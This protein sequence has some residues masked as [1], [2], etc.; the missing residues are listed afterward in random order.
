MGL[1]NSMSEF[2]EIKLEK[3]K[4]EEGISKLYPSLYF[5][6]DEVPEMEKLKF[7]KEYEITL[8]VKPRSISK[9]E[10]KEKKSGSID[11][12][13]IAYKMDDIDK[14]EAEENS[15]GSYQKRD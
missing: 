10:E 2:K 1:I 8:K 11:L 9:R 12:D 14:K 6:F 5:S 15:E 3:P 13:I 4:K 7:D